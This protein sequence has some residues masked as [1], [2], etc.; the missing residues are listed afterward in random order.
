MIAVFKKAN[1]IY[2]IYQEG[3]FTKAA[4]KLFISQ[5]CLSAAVKRTEQLVGGPLFERG[6][7]GVQPTELGVEYIR[8]AEQIL[9]LEEQFSHRLKDIHE[10]NCGKVRVGG[11]NYIS[12][13]ILPRILERF[14]GKYPNVTVSLTE[15][16]SGKLTELLEQ[17]QLDLVVDSFDT[18][19]EEGS[20]LLREKIL[21]AVPGTFT[22]N[23]L[24]KGK[25][26]TPRALFDDPSR[27]SAL[28]VVSAGDFQQ[29]RFILLKD[30]HSMHRHAMDIFRQAGFMPQVTLFLDQL[31][32]SY[33]LCAQGN[34]CCFVT[35]TVFR[36]HRFEDDVLLYNVAGSG[37]RSLAVVGKPGK[38]LT[39]AQKAFAEI[40]EKSIR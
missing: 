22:C 4:G 14:T 24:L 19:A 25:G 33:S 12:S 28:P 1:Y 23:T 16:D 27:V 10:L 20:V 11:S 6:G 18:V 37:C 30:G 21:L 26:I 17:E 2:T 9:A 29:E 39:P 8:T 32:T 36:Y 38:P 3:S 34:G 13:Y 5:P 31:S 15:A 40:A 7:S 35:D